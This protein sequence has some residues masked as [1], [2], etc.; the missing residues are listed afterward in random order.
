MSDPI[1]SAALP[2]RC[3]AFHMT[4]WLTPYRTAISV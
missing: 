4:F 1:R 3:I 2:I